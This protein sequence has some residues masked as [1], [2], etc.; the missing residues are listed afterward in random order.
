MRIPRILVIFLAGLGLLAAACS[1]A[2]GTASV[3]DTAPD[4]SG[5]DTATTPDPTPTAEPS[6]TP[7][8]EDDPEP[9]EPGPDDGPVE[10]GTLRIGLGEV[11]ALDPAAASLGSQSQLIVADL[12]FDGLT[13]WDAE[14]G[15][16]VPALATEWTLSLDLD[17][18]T[19]SLDGDAEFS[20]GSP[21]TARDVKASLERVVAADTVGV[22]ATRLEVVSGFAAFAEGD[23]DGISGLV[24]EDDTTLRVQLDEPMFALPW[25]L[26]S[27][28]YGV[29]PADGP[30]GDGGLL[31]LVGSG[32]MVLDD[33]DGGV[34]SLVPA[35]RVDTWVDAVEIAT[36]DASDVAGAVE[37]G[38]HDIVVVPR[39]LSADVAELDGAALAVETTPFHAQVYLGLNPRVG[40][41]SNRDLRRAVA[42]AVDAEAVVAGVYGMTA[43]V[44][45]GFVPGW[46]TCGGPCGGDAE[47][48][49][50]I[51]QDV[52][53]GDTPTV[54][55]D[56]IDDEALPE[57]AEI[58]ALVAAQL[59]D[60][61]IGVELRGWSV[62]DYI[63][64]LAAGE[65]EIFRF[66]WVGV[67]AGAESWLG[68][69][70]TGNLDN[71]IALRSGSVDDALEVARSADTV[72]EADEAYARAEERLLGSDR[73][74]PLAE[75]VTLV[76]VSE[77]LEGL[78]VRADGT[79][80][81]TSVWFSPRGE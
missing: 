58:A 32:P 74:V 9:P 12:L 21:V 76:A 22:A 17:A 30:T 62:D 48:A 73:A 61:G 60:A 66:G 20:D 13:A 64:R 39:D 41:L 15:E 50:T 81:V 1:G 52:F 68:H 65:L 8:P 36:L 14:E 19:F 7:T 5:T 67:G 59:E 18:W 27:P 40:E 79:F 44:A 11:G 38:D 34:L 71:V 10:G 23:A 54:A 75:F 45:S 56:Y 53:D 3:A 57:D 43:I 6:P 46:D 26:S 29:V 25:I 72:A 4:D 16:L 42:A 63:E 69:Y 78:T 47:A 31:S 2:E 80:D 77:D 24:A 70:E 37:S 35:D 33:V 28:V 51:V 49:R 55:V